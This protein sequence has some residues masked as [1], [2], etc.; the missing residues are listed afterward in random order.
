MKKLKT[1][2]IAASLLM[3]FSS[4]EKES[5]NKC[6]VVT[7]VGYIQCN[8]FDCY[9]YLPI[10]WDNG[11]TSNQSVDQNTWINYNIGQKICF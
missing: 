5:A 7:G 10:K 11:T 9:Y 2:L 8:T 6:G 1:L 3:M 4:C